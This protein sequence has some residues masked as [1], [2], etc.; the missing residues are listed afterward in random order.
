MTSTYQTEQTA[1]PI[2]GYG[3][4]YRGGGEGL[5]LIRWSGRALKLP[6]AAAWVS[7]LWGFVTLGIAV[8][9]VQHAKWMS[10][11][12][13]LLW[14]L[15][16]SMASTALL[17]RLKLHPLAK[18]MAAVVF[19]AFVLYLQVSRMAVG[20]PVSEAFASSPNENTIAFGL[21]LAIVVW[22]VGVI[23][24]WWLLRR[25]SGWLPAGMGAAILLVNLSNLPAESYVILPFYLIASLILVGLA[26]FGRHRSDF[27]AERNRYPGFGARF[28]ILAVVMCAVVASLVA[29]FVPV[30]AVDYVGFDASGQ[31][32]ASVQKNWL[33]VFASVPG[34][35]STMRNEDL[36]QLSFGSPL[37]NRE[38]V[39]FTVTSP[40]PAYWRLKRYTS[41]SPWGWD[42]NA[43]S[44]GDAVKAG[45]VNEAGLS[46]ASR[47]TLT[48]TV[49]TNEKTD[50]LVV[51]GEFVSASIPVRLESHAS[52]PD[53]ASGDLISIITPNLLQPRQRYTV[54][55]TVSRA[56]PEQ[57]TQAGTDYP[58]WVTLRYLDLPASLPPRVRLLATRLTAAVDN[59]YDK[60]VVIQDFL[61]AFKYNRDARSSRGGD[62]TDNFL[63][64]RREGACT[65]FATAMVVMLRATGV[66]AR[67]ATGY[68]SGEHQ[69]GSQTY[70]VRGRDYHAWPEV[71][72]PG[73]GWIEFEPTP[74]SGTISPELP[75][76]SGGQPSL[77]DLYPPEMFDSGFAGVP[78]T[79]SYGE[80][81]RSPNI[82]LPVTLAVLLG[83]AVVGIVWVTV[84]RL[85][86]NLRYSGDAA[87]VYS[88]MCRLA[89][90]AGAHPELTETPIEYCGRLAAA[91]PEGAR[92]IGDIGILY[93]E[94]RFS[95]RKEL[96][97]AQLVRLQKS[98]VELYPVL[99]K[100]RFPWNR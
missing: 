94:S 76:T 53:H 20:R 63:F 85:Y 82:A 89:G 5:A 11:Q 39:L 83:I 78:P 45:T 36:R 50:V 58:D 35:W 41:Y 86:S 54:T 9:S 95:P 24:T 31:F 90:F 16:W 57:L 29:W 32:I 51:A 98:W 14:L 46:G 66:P 69:E 18:R 75:A 61:K 68:L 56:T 22:V 10:S 59:P 44:V 1:R 92:A 34:K 80:T 73:Y 60:A 52:A 4:Y 96:D 74:R 42:S 43:A 100:R 7:V 37:D 38:T 87:T 99:F 19:G 79:V 49:D 47:E 12:P 70:V 62:E 26:Q 81:P 30:G 33:N 64:V 15:F 27:S 2:Y 40:Q 71:Y 67:L 13:A 6:G 93:A 72:F 23:S 65:D 25:G 77:E 88:K 97:E 17:V 8:Y 28:F 84:S 3:S 21:F 55:T 91:F 48:Y